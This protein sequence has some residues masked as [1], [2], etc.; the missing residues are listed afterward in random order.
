MISVNTIR[1]DSVASVAGLAIPVTPEGLFLLQMPANVSQYQFLQYMWGKYL[2]KV[3]LS[4][5]A[6]EV[7]STG[8]SPLSVFRSV[9]R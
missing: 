6:Q 5:S 4:R 7:I 2:Y 1:K 3:I 9:H 8:V